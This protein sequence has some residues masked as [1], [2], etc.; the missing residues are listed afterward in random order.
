MYILISS[1]TVV[2]VHKRSNQIKKWLMC[3]VYR[4]GGKSEVTEL[5]WNASSVA[6][7]EL[8][9]A[10]E[11]TGQFISAVLFILFAFVGV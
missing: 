4:G 2:G 8:Y 3:L 5:N 10:N 11:L 9:K 6:L 7:H 1:L